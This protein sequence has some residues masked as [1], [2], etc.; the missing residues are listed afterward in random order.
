MVEVDEDLG[1]L[2]VVLVP[3][4]GEQ[5]FFVPGEAVDVGL[6]KGSSVSE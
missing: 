1:L 5:V 4:I 3:G 6:L 2:D